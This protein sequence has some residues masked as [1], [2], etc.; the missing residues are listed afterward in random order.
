MRAIIF[1]PEAEQQYAYWRK[2]DKKT[3]AKVD[4]LIDEIIKTPFEGIG[5]PEPL[6]HDLGGYWS[7]RI[8]KDGSQPVAG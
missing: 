4:Q 3:L 5:K 1:L 2:Y 6:K 8:T 7:R